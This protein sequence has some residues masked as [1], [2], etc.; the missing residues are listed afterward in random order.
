MLPY[1]YPQRRQPL[2]PEVYI[3]TLFLASEREMPVDVALT[4]GRVSPGWP[5]VLS[6]LLAAGALCEGCA[7][8]G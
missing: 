3:Y 2:P 1:T 8:G 7:G 5:M 4:L 6:G